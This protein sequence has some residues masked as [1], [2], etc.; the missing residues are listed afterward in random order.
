MGSAAARKL[1]DLCC[2]QAPEAGGNVCSKE[3]R[4]E[5]VRLRNI[6]KKLDGDKC[7]GP[8]GTHAERAG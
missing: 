1:P 3:E 2:L 4:E 8:D 6:E 7:T 5:S